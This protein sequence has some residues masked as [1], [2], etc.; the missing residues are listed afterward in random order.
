MSSSLS[1]GL[2]NL[3]PGNIR[4]S[5]TRYKGE[6]LS[7]TD[8]SFKQF[9]S[10]EAGYRAM[11][12]LLHT[13]RVRGY[14]NTIAQ[15]IARYAPPSE[16]NTDAYVA[17]VSKSAKIDRNTPIDTLSAVQMIP[18]VAAMSAVENGT[19]ADIV[20]VERGWQLFIAD[21]GE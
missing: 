15:F 6:K 10:I 20:A 19:V 5:K 17:R 12:V 21:F 14:G 4:H 8:S 2:R 11:F 18:I 16:N 3:N 13:Y 9:E 1:R 7:S